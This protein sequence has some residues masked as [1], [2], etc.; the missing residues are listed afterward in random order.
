[1]H[2]RPIR[3]DTDHEAALRDIEALWGADEGTEAGARLDV[4][5]TLVEVYEARRWPIK[6]VDL[7]C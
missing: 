3:T 2:T 5:F 4:L 1:M 7:T 6:L